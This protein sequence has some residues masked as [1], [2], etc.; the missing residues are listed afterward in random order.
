[1][2][3][4]SRRPLACVIGTMDLVRPL[5]LA[6][7]RCAVV[8]R[9]LARVRHSRFVTDVIEWADPWQEPDEL[10]DRLLA[11][12]RVQPEKPVLYYEGDWDLLLVSRLRARLADAFRFVVPDRDLVERLV[13]KERFAAFADE[14]DLPV[15]P[16]RRV[17]AG[18]PLDVTELQFP[19]LVKPITRQVAT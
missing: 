4:A 13:D 3:H 17:T 10:M 9:P 6:G 12:G 15:P 11:F 2:A 14:L 18:S 1:M 16:S 7:V 8:A 5:G 19:V